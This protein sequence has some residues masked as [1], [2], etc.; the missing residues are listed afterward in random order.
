[1]PVLTRVNATM[2]FSKFKARMP[3]LSVASTVSRA[4]SKSDCSIVTQVQK[5]G[6]VPYS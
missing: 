6:A 5:Q 4:A 2:P 1:M 3:V